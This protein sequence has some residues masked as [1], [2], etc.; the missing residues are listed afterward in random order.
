VKHSPQKNYRISRGIN[1][2]VN[3]R[4]WGAS[5]KCS[6]GRKRCCYLQLM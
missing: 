1:S 4:L 3:G 5:Y 2:G 6:G